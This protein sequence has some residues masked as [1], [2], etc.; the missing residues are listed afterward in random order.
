MKIEKEYYKEWQAELDEIVAEAEAAD[1]A[2]T[3]EERAADEAQSLAAFHR[4]I[5]E[6]EEQRARSWV[7]QKH[8]ARLIFKRLSEKLLVY[9][10]EDSTDIQI[11]TNEEHGMIRMEFDQLILDNLHPAWHWRLWRRLMKHAD[12]IWVNP[13]EKYGESALQYTFIFDFQ[14]SIEWKRK[15]RP[16]YGQIP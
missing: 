13:I 7:F 2:M 15:R 12:D 11:E 9:A 1:A 8:L 6:A 3:D 5:A 16:N 14:W 10:Q 4:I